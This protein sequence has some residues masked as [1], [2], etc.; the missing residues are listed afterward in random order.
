MLVSP[1]I[2]CP[3]TSPN[4][5][6]KFIYKWFQCSSSN[7]LNSLQID[8]EVTGLL[9]FSNELFTILDGLKV[10][11]GVKPISLSFTHAPSKKVVT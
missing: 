1:D 3:S 7:I 8:P 6:S 2:F 9:C 5:E 10:N 4:G 11:R